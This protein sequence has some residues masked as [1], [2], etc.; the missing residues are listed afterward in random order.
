[1]PHLVNRGRAMYF[2]ESVIGIRRRLPGMKSS[3][4]GETGAVRQCYKPGSGKIY[5]PCVTVMLFKDV[6][7]V[8]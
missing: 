2:A 8:I 1:M 7:V 4:Y 6:L 3:P 5:F